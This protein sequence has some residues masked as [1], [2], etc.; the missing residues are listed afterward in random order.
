MKFKISIILLLC[1]FILPNQVIAQEPME[2]IQAIATK[3]AE[4]GTRIAISTS[5][6]ARFRSYWLDEPSRLVVEFRTRNILSEID[7]EVI[8]NQGVIKRITSGYYKRGRRR[9]LKSLTFELTQRV[10]YKIW[11]ENDTIILD[12]MA[13]AEMPAPIVAEKEI[14]SRTEVTDEMIK[15]L[16]AMEAALTETAESK[17]SVETPEVELEEENTPKINNSEGEATA[18]TIIL[19]TGKPAKERRAIP[20]AI[21]WLTGLALISGSGLLLWHR[22][23]K[24]KTKNIKKRIGSLETELQKKD[25]HLQHEET[26]R[27]A[28]EKASVEKEKEYKELQLKLKEKDK[29]IKEEEVLRKKVEKAALEEKEEYEKLKSS[30]ESLKDTLVERGLAKKAVSEEGKETLWIPGKSEERRILPRLT[31][32]R[33]YNKTIILRVESLSKSELIKTFADN[34]CS[35]GLCFESKKEF[36]EKEPLTLRLFFYG[37]R[38]PSMKIQARIVWQKTIG[39][40]NYYGVSFSLLDEK[41]KLELTRYIESKIVTA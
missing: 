17:P 5:G 12:I 7:D 4:S 14:F 23:N 1:V 41:D 27:K 13:P 22:S 28:V 30:Y 33:D 16:E 39:P 25:K 32:T 9:S 18:P 36:E 2:E 40:I 11:Q 15:R 20:G 8:V 21:F 37:D 3:E 31:L 19:P 26:I 10:P 24:Y 34:I 38:I 35:E 6:P 29:L